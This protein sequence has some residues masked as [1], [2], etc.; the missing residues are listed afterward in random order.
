M[1][2]CNE[3]VNIWMSDFKNDLEINKTTIDEE[4][5]EVEG[6]I[7]NERIWLKGSSTEEETNVHNQNI[8][9]LCAYLEA[10]KVLKDEQ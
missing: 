6:T 9:N 8:A 2:P 7:S 10:L 3:T 4:I 5:K 1:E